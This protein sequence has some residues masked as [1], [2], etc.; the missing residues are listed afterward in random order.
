S[1]NIRLII[2]SKNV[3]PSTHIAL[4]SPRRSYTPSLP[5][6]SNRSSNPSATL[7]LSFAA[8]DV[9]RYIEYSS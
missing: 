4:A 8:P 5:I 3:L 6:E 2:L 1:P 9:F 7:F